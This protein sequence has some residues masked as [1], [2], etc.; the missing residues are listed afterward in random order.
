MTRRN[1][2][3]PHTSADQYSFSDK[4]KRRKLGGRLRDEPLRDE[5]VVTVNTTSCWS[6]KALRLGFGVGQPC[7]RGAA[8]NLSGDQQFPTGTS[9]LTNGLGLR[10]ELPLVPWR[11]AA[12][13]RLS[14]TRSDRWP[15]SVPRSRSSREPW[16]CTRTG[17]SLYCKDDCGVRRQEA[18]LEQGTG[19][20]SGFP[21]T[22]ARS[23]GRRCRVL[24]ERPAAA[25]S[26]RPDRLLIL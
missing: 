13:A 7:A 14:L 22:A 8:N 4:S 17:D 12:G 16:I 5:A 1:G 20:R 6:S 9:K 3:H 24:L 21:C 19:S 25:V 10:R 18:P 2:G 11:G 15:A 23:T 26:G